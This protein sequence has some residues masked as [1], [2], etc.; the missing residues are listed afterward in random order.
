MLVGISISI[1]FSVVLIH[2]HAEPHIWYDR[3]ERWV[4]CLCFIAYMVAWVPCWL[5][6]FDMMGLKARDESNKRC[7]ELEYSWLQFWWM[8]VYITNLSLGYLTY[9]FAR[10]YLDAGGFTIRHRIYQAGVYVVRWYSVAGIVVVALIAAIAFGTHQV[11][12]SGFWDMTL[13]VG[14]ALANFYAVGIFIWLLAHA[15]VEIPRR[16]YYLSQDEWCQRYACFQV[17]PHALHAPHAPR[18]DA[19]HASPPAPG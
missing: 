4:L 9:D 6:P 11:T 15:V 7:N 19:T 5:L 16:V 8:V 18:R 13:A 3:Q 14:Y 2:S 1:V 12:D 10:S 17:C